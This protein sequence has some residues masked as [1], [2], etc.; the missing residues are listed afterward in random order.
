[1]S[2]KIIVGG[3]LEGNVGSCTTQVVSTTSARPKWWKENVVNIAT[4][5]CTGQVD[6]Y[7]SWDFTPAGFFLGLPLSIVT[8]FL[9]SAMAFLFFDIVKSFFKK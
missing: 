7:Y 9:A 3:N 5:S 1:M 6:K 4:N 2:D 8:I